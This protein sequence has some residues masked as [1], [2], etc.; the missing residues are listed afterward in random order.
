MTEIIF[1]I[2]A[3]FEQKLQSKTGWG[4]N[5]VIKLHDEVVIQVLARHVN[6]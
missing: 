2:K 3:E 5:E 6:K 1:E 4:K